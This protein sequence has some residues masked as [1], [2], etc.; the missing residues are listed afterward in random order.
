MGHEVRHMTSEEIKKEKEPDD[1]VDLTEEDAP[2]SASS[3]AHTATNNTQTVGS[4]K[5]I[6]MF[7][8]PV[9]NCNF[10]KTRLSVRNHIKK[11][12]GNDSRFLSTIK[13]VLKESQFLCSLCDNKPFL[14]KGGLRMHQSKSHGNFSCV[15]CGETFA[16]SNAHKKHMQWHATAL[17]Q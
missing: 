7:V 13:R 1:M 16:K 4:G 12:H 9:T 11:N 5:F 15:L 10:R 8:C 14:T 17:Q 6:E 2:E 3:A